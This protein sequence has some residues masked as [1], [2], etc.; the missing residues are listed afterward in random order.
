MIQQCYDV[1]MDYYCGNSTP[2]RGSFFIL[3]VY[4]GVGI[5]RGEEQKRTGKTAI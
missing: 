1:I 5:S 4:K 2:V 3:D